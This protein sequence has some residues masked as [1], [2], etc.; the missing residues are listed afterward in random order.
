M[1]NMPADHPSFEATPSRREAADYLRDMAAQL[2]ALA[3]GAGL[4]DISRAFAE[5]RDRCDDAL[6]E[7]LS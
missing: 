4:K 7:G 5:A 2:A 6:E 3:Q 1:A